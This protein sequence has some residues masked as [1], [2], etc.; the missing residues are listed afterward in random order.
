MK[1]RVHD[2]MGQGHGTRTAKLV[3]NTASLLGVVLVAA[4]VGWALRQDSVTIPNSHAAIPAFHALPRSAVAWPH[5][6][7]VFPP[8]PVDGDPFIAAAH[9]EMFIPAGLGLP[10]GSTGSSPGAPSMARPAAGSHA[11]AHGAGSA[12]PNPY[13]NP[14]P[15][16]ARRSAQSPAFRTRKCGTRAGGHCHRRTQG[17]GPSPVPWMQLCMLPELGDETRCAASDTERIPYRTPVNTRQ[18]EWPR[19]QVG[20]RNTNRPTLRRGARVD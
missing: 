7:D 6:D 15:A 9:P 8:R 16:A 12:Y 17:S 3:R 4:A 1:A 13:L 5:V 11:V 20:T 14:L 10:L 18:N 2:R 19:A